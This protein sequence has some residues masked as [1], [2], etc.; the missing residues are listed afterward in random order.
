MFSIKNYGSYILKEDYGRIF[1]KFYRAESYIS[2]ST[3]GSGLG[4]YIADNLAKQMNGR[5]ELNSDKD[6]KETEF[7]VYL[8]V[9]EIEKI[10]KCIEPQ[11]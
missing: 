8:P 10:T 11:S 9:F 2:A 4:L 3:Q 5:I 7:L 6:K 1:E